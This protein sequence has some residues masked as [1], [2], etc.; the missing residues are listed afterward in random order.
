LGQIPTRSSEQK[1]GPAKLA[2]SAPEQIASSKIS[3]G[4]E[5]PAM[6]TSE[7]IAPSDKPA[8][9]KISA[10]KQTANAKV[11]DV[12]PAA[13]VSSEPKRSEKPIEQTATSQPAGK[14][15]PAQIAAKPAVEQTK[16][17]STSGVSKP[18]PAS[19]LVTAAKPNVFEQPKFEKVKPQDPQPLEVRKI[20]PLSNAPKIEVK[21]GDTKSPE[22]V[23]AIEKTTESREPPAPIEKKKTGSGSTEPKP[24]VKVPE[25]KSTPPDP[26]Q[27][28][29]TP[30]SVTAPKS[31]KLAEL[32]SQPVEAVKP[33]VQ[34]IEVKKIEPPS[35]APKIEVKREENKSPEQAPTIQKAL[36]SREQ[37]RPVEK[38]KTQPASMPAKSEVKI[39]EAKSPPPAQVQSQQD[40]V[41]EKSAGEQI[42]LLKNKTSESAPEKKAVVPPVRKALE[43]FIIQLAF[44]DKATAQRWAETLERRGYAVSVTEAGGAGSLRVRMGN[45]AV[46]DEAERQLRSL[47]QEGLAGI[48][49]NL[50]Q[51]YRPEGRP[52]AIE[53][54]GKGAS[55]VQ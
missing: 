31:G 3:G 28:K 16:M 29:P 52:S 50:P 45:F 43:G 13:K 14:G 24:E 30:V 10:A 21:R 22:H 51:A 34:P 25:T 4:A 15:A 8:E 27:A 53:G 35:D 36:E 38:E 18:E 47:R 23:T 44:T 32:K 17:E 33:P 42:A 49:L 9:A 11:S 26:A 40:K 6:K 5:K 39:A 54:D 41:S 55:V 1:P 12:E 20:D 19:P 46:R 7:T 48:I 37:P 2:D